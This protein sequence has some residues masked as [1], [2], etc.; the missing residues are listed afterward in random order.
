[1]TKILQTL[2]P[3]WQKLLA[4]ETQKPYFLALETFLEEAFKSATIYPPAYQILNAFNQ[5]ALQN[6][7]VVILGQDP[8]HGANQAHGLAFSVNDGVP[9][10]PSLR[11]IFKEQADDLG[12]LQ[13]KNGNLSDWAAQGVLLLNATL[14][15]QADQAASHQKMGWETFT[16]AVIEL[17]SERT[18]NT[19]F[20]LW[21]SYAQQKSVLINPAKHLILKSVHPSPLSAHRGFLGCKHFSQANAYL[22]KCGKQPIN[23]QL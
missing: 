9:V 22:I 15:V 19:V 23:W 11:N 12:I 4:P 10:P 8:Y 16:D 13:P 3:N 14:T 1:M 20:L 17:V 7:R 5:T 6:I 2:D 21:G 18:E